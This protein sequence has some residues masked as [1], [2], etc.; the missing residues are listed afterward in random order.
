VNPFDHLRKSNPG[1][2]Y[3]G[4][5]LENTPPR[6]SAEAIREKYEKSQEKK[7]ELISGNGR[8]MKEKNFK[9]KVKVSTCASTYLPPPP[10]CKGMDV[11]STPAEFLC[12][13]R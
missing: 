8:M 6:I 9:S 4:H 5:I 13:S 3:R 10:S 7:K 2:D 1:Q 12:V 11:P